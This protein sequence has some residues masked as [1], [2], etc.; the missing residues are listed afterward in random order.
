[1]GSRKEKEGVWAAKCGGER[2]VAVSVSG[3]ERLRCNLKNYSRVRIPLP[4]L[5]RSSSRRRRIFDFSKDFFSL[6]IQPSENREEVLQQFLSFKISSVRNRIN[7]EAW[8]M[9]FLIWILNR[10]NF[11]AR[12]SRFY[13]RCCVLRFVT[14]PC[15]TLTVILRGIPDQLNT[16][17]DPRIINP[18]NR[19]NL[20]VE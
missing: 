13:R 12:A 19:I 2:V 15:S 11:R 14:K 10:I 7:R 18:F 4:P 6:P 3:V 5:S 9:K 1:M 8:K 17:H 16:P 20:L